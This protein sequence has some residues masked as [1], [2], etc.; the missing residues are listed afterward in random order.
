MLAEVDFTVEAEGHSPP[1]IDLTVPDTR[2]LP[3]VIEAIED[4]KVKRE[5]QIQAILRRRR[6][7]AAR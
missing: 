7:A 6:A 1:V 3:M 2:F 5:E 4:R